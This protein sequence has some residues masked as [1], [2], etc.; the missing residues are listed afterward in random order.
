MNSIKVENKIK[1]NEQKGLF[2]EHVEY[3][4]YNHMKKVKS[5]YKYI[6]KNPFYKL[7]KLLAR[8]ICFMSWFFFNNFI[9]HTKVV[10][11]KNINGI[12]A[13][14][15]TS[16]H[17]HDLDC[18]FIKRT[19][20]PTRLYVTVGEFNNYKGIFGSL[21]RAGGILPFTDNMVAMKHLNKAIRELLNKKRKIL[22]Y[23]E[24]ACWPFYEKPRPFMDGA[25]YYASSNNVPIIPTFITWRI[26]GKKK[27]PIVNIMKPIYP[28]V[29]LSKKENIIYLKEENMKIV[30]QKYE[31]FYRKE[32]VYI[33]K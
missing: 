24:A 25:F 28:K 27:R 33:T 15:I 9:Y 31:E 19:F 11:K 7:Y 12:K 26:K 30:K 17:V 8:T 6:R 4:N 22:F 10:G 2:H 3:V 5:D 29:E 18:L 20:F 32:L 1:E 21:L 16:N 23:P 13:A 14:I